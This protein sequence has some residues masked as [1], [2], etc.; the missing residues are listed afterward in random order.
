MAQLVSSEAQFL[1]Y[2]Y[3]SGSECV[4]FGG[5]VI[6][7]IVNGDRLR[8]SS[9]NARRKQHLDIFA[10]LPIIRE[11]FPLRKYSAYAIET[12]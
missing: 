8:K 3:Q 9:I 7:D 12:A 10:A 1:E 6:D 11:D 2:V 5:V 4:P